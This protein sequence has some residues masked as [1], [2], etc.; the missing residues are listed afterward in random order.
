MQE[1]TVKIQGMSCRSCV[2]TIEGALDSIGAEGHVNFEQGT[3]HV[4]YDEA[5][6]QLNDI[7]EAIENK[8]YNVL[9]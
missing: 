5:K 7:K 2:R 1:A 3:V 8:G 6:V 4:Q 9:V